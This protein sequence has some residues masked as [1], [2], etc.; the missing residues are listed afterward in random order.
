MSVIEEN[1]DHVHILIKSEAKSRYLVADPIRSNQTLPTQTT[2]S[3]TSIHEQ[4][5]PQITGFRAEH[6]AHVRYQ[7][8]VL[9]KVPS[10]F[11][12]HFQ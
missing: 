12:F 3:R 4:S 8:T 2:P 11:F 1:A 5:F 6:S 7:I 10:T 9:V